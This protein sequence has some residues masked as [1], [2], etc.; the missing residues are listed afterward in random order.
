MA[1]VVLSHWCC[2]QGQVKPKP[3]ELLPETPHLVFVT[4]YV[5]ELAAIEDIRVSGQQEL[6]QDPTAALSDAIHSS[7]LFQ[8]ELGS[9]IRMLDGMR[10]NP[11]YDEIVPVITEGYAA[12]IA[13]FQRLSDICSTML[14]GPEPGV[15][16]GKLAAEMPKIRAQLD[17]VDQS[18]FQATPLV[19]ATLIDPKANSR[20]QADHLIITRADRDKL[21]EDLNTDFGSKIDAKGQDYT[22]TAASVLKAYL[23]KDYK[24]SDEPWN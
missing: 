11:P 22:V 12:K 23:L 4:E 16:Y 3:A 6:K 19:F 15:D 18:L 21:V 10:L 14:A 20:N 5:R 9:Q 17:Y 7:T 8:L 24:C 1:V 13:L 2:A